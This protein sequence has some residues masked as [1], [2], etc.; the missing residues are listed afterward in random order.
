[1]YNVER[2][3]ATS[4][5][6]SCYEEVHQCLQ[7]NIILPHFSMRQ[8]RALRLKALPYQLVRFTESTT[9]SFLSSAQRHKIQRE[10]YVICMMD[11]PE[12]TLL[13]TQLCTKSQELVSTGPHCLKMHKLMSASSQSVTDASTKLEGQQPCY[14]LLQWNNHSNGGAQTSLGKSSHIH[15]SNT[16]TF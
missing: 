2:A 1:M 9:M 14:K 5:E 8:K 12:V 10:C 15:Q 4:H 11:Q 6:K 7:H 16:T 13:V 3:L